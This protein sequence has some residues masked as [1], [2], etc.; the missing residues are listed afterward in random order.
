MKNNE[1]RIDSFE[2]EEEVR[3]TKEGMEKSCERRN[4]NE[5]RE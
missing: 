5:R 3:W 1:R 4:T 2:R